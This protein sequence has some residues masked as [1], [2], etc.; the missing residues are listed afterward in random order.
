[1]AQSVKLNF[2]YNILL[3]ISK[4]LFPLITAPYV[5]RVLEPDG[6]GLFNF[7]GTYVNYFALFAILGTSL[8][9]IREI[10]KMRDDL[11]AQ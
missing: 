1:M 11:K 5:A 4:V 6:I 3:N 7:A 10:A 2:F 9:S 8:Y